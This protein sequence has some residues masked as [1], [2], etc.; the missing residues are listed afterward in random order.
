MTAWYDDDDFWETLEGFFFQHFR[1]PEITVAEVDKIDDLL[2]P[3]PGAA[4]LDLACGTGRH[5]LEFARRGFRV[6]G[7]D[8]T[9]RYLE[10]ARRGARD[11]GLDVEFVQA[12][13][14]RVTGHGEFDIV[15]S[16]F[17]SLGYF[18]D[19]D[20]DLRVLRNAHRSLKPGGRFLLELMG[21]E[22][23][24]RDFRPRGW[25]RRTNAPEYLLEERSIRDGW[26]WI[27]NHWIVIR[28]TG[29]KAFTFRMRLYSGAELDTALRAAGFADVRLHGGFEGI[30]YDH[31]ATRLVAVATKSTL[32]TT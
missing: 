10:T 4:V 27:E 12:D 5:A 22:V 18:E 29:P 8:R 20:D 3:P 31:T 17:S 24:A 26:G 9:V 6:T 7:V 25:Y 1:T 14:R 30:P 2:G 11:E 13:M 28:A 15:L 16:L 23:L 32:P 21:K 19:A